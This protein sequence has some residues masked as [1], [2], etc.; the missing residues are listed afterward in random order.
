MNA[1]APLMPADKVGRLL[2]RYQALKGFRTPWESLWKEIARYVS[3]R[4]SPGLQGTVTA[5]TTEEDSRLFDITAVQSAQTLANGCLAWMSPQESPWFA[6]TP[7]DNLDDDDASKWLNACTNTARKVLARSN[8][9]L[10]VHEFYLDRSTFGTGALYIGESSKGSKRI[11]VQHWS[12]GSYVID[13]DAEGDVDTVIHEM[14]LTPLAAAQ[15]F[16]IE[17]LSKGMRKIVD[18]GGAGAVQ[19]AKF[20]H[21]IFPR[22]KAD[23]KEGSLAPEHMPVGCVYMEENGSHVCRVSGYPEMPVMVSKYLEWGSTMG[24]RYGWSPSFSALPEA[25]QLNFLQKMM[26]AMAERAAFPAV[27]APE[28]LEGELDPNANAVTYFDSNIA[29]RLPRAWL[30]EGRYDIGKDRVIEGQ[31]AIKAAYHVDLFQMF[32]DLNKQMTAREVAERSSEKLVQFSPTF[33]R[34]T[35]ELFNPFLERLFGIGLRMGWFAEPPE[36]LMVDMGDGTAYVAPPEVLYSSRI[37]L[38]LRGLPV[39][40]IFRMAELT[41]GLIELE[42]SG[43]PVCDNFNFDRAWQLAAINEALPDG[44]A[45]T[46]D[47]VAEIRNQRAAAQ[48]EAAQQEQA[49]AMSEQLSK[50]GKVPGDTPVGSAMGQQI[51]GMAA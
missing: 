9:Y 49:M 46:D 41:K 8:F 16:G 29:G 27:L 12:I 15:E 3:P 47:E 5:P 24:N 13:E 23:Q 40:S 17:N 6:F 10:A 32:Q 14:L 39:M 43:S 11:N 22:D 36:S 2:Q 31:N 35:T 45:R 48:A 28:E 42:L 26:D 37:A 21:F 7:D 51:E 50:L 30:T 20:L 1:Q 33:A 34:L 18:D 4:R 25:R 38:A 19:P 44:I